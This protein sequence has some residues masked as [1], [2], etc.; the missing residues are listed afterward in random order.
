MQSIGFAVEGIQAEF[1]V[2][3]FAVA[4]IPFAMS[5]VGIL[6]VVPFGILTDRTRRT[7]LLAAGTL[8]WTLAMG[9]TGLA[10]SFAMLLIARMAVG[11]LESTS[12]AAVSLICDYWPV[13][14]RAAKMGLYQFGAFCGA[15]TAFG[16][17]SVAVSLGGW[18]WAFFMWVPFG[19]VATGLLLKAP[20]PRR[21][22]QDLAASDAAGASPMGAC[23]D[24]EPEGAARVAALFTLPT[25]TRIGSGDYREMGYRQAFGEVLRIRSMWFGLVTITVGQLL[26]SGLG[27]W[28]IPYFKRV[29]ELGDVAAGGL[30]GMLALGSAAGIVGGGYL[31]DRLVRKGSVNGRVHIIAAASVGASLLLV[32]AFAS[33]SLWITSPL[34]VLGGLLLTLPIAP[35]EALMADV[36]VCDLRGRAATLR[37]IVRTL[38]SAGP[39]LIGALSDVVGLRWALVLFMPLYAV[40]GLVA[41]GA[42][43]TYAADLA[44]V[45]AETERTEVYRRARELVT[46]APLNQS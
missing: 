43:R 2:S 34:F 35:A 29:H 5:L 21:G 3:D 38:S 39:L 16:L 46:E 9:L 13:Q 22:E 23:S 44:F 17:G 15:I 12:P 8:T 19:L 28:G 4:T 24:V 1:G 26:L 42:R 37:S 41:L 36:V 6:G 20:E 10:G 18:R 40:G 45:L 11:A 25:P 30:V 31:S 27:F 33:T 32:P 14:K 7:L